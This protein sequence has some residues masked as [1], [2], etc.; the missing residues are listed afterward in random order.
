[1]SKRGENIYKRKDS[2]WEGRFIKGHK[3]NGKI[4]Y[5]YVYGK[6]YREVKS[7]LYQAK[8]NEEKGGEKNNESYSFSGYCDRWLRLRRNQVKESTYGHYTRIV[9]HH[10][11]PFFGL[12]KVEQIN[13]VLIEE[14]SNSLLKQ[15]KLEAKTV[16]DI[17]RVLKAILCY[18]QK[19][20]PEQIQ[21][22]DIMFPSEKKQEL[23][24]LSK[25]EQERLI[26]FLLADL[27]YVKFGIVLA[28]FTGLRIGE[29]CALRW[30]DI[31]LDERILLIRSTVQRISVLQ[32]D[33]D[34]KTKIVITDPKSEKSRRIIPL[35][36][37]LV[38]L[39]QKM[40]V[41]NRDA[42]VLTADENHL[43]EPRTLQYRLAKYT[44]EL[45]LQGVHFHV[46]RH[47]FATR[48]VEV[49]F[50][51]KAL[52]EIMGH[53][54]VQITLNRYVHSSLEQKRANMEKLILSNSF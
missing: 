16:K 23:R 22:I 32:E 24:V 2:R 19:E 51:I 52:S 40:E 48:C 14:F 18:T 9:Y 54:D 45:G 37:F 4:R 29:L 33:T 21:N 46:L 43:M 42:F 1:M 11:V 7:K 3:E 25:K 10:I 8:S 15:R 17:L 34:Q 26:D 27:D 13:T 35:N 39:C 12:F 38:S 5:G 53:S 47:S 31:L 50:D 49:G 41:Q 44:S 30:K 6:S 20:V 28:L 36:E